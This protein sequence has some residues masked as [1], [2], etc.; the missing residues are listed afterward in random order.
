[1]TNPI[2][3]NSDYKDIDIGLTDCDRSITIVPYTRQFLGSN[4]QTAL[5]FHDWCYECLTR[6]IKGC[7]N[8]SVYTITQI[9]PADAPF[10]K[11]TYS[12]PRQL[13]PAGRL[14][15]LVSHVD[16]Q[17]ISIMKKL[18]TEIRSLIWEYTGFET[19]ASSYTLVAGEAAQLV[20]AINPA[21]YRDISRKEGPNIL[22]KMISVF[23]RQYIRD[24]LV[25]KVV[26]RIDFAIHLGGLCAIKIFG[27]DGDSGWFGYLPET[28]CVWYGTISGP[29]SDL[30]CVFN[31]S[32][33]EY[34]H[35]VVNLGR[36]CTAPTSQPRI[37]FRLVKFYGIDLIYHHL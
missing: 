30:Y 31:V 13:D 4:D 21:D 18:P 15:T 33:N 7:T 3:F 20:R 34:L 27:V 2:S 14:R 37:Y 5:C 28:S 8:L 19:A 24:L 32:Q 9:L 1:M 10:Y 6:E 17:P 26:T 36:A 16:L 12:A 29:C 25:L 11:D 22:V 23:G 35:N